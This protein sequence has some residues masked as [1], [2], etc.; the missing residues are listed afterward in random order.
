M[1]YVTG[2]IVLLALGYA[3]CFARRPNHHDRMTIEEH[4][5]Q[6]TDAILEIDRNR[7][8]EEIEKEKRSAEQRLARAQE[9]LK[10]A[11]EGDVGGIDLKP[12]PAAGDEGS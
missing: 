7:R 10:K 4:A 1:F 8:E 5:V 11:E 12:A 9:M 2:T 6:A 3:R